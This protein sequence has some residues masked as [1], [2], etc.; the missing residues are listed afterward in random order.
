M[1]PA[2]LPLRDIHLP[3]P[4]GFWPPAPGWWVLGA[5]VLLVLVLAAR[6]L[7]RWWRQRRRR[8]RLIAALDRLL[9]DLPVD[10]QAAA[11][12]LGDL[13]VFLRRWTKSAYPDA[14]ALNGAAWLN[15]LDGG[16]PG[17]PFSV[18]AGR[19][20][21]DGPFRR[22][23]DPDSLR[24]IGVLLRKRLQAPRLKTAGKSP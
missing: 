21:E 24:E 11:L 7:T 1:N 16:D 9:G 17:K 23:V 8:V 12:K 2:E 13:S 6:F 5:I 15:F 14:I 4:P 19:L 22:Q 3:S 20:L 18:G 10:A